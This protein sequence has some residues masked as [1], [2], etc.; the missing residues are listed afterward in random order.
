MVK[1]QTD[2]Y[3]AELRHLDYIKRHVAILNKAKL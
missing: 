3:S 2:R 1:A